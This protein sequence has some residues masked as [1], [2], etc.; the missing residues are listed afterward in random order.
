MARLFLP[1]FL[2]LDG[3][4]RQGL[5][6][7]GRSQPSFLHILPWS[8]L[9]SVVR[10]CCEGASPALFHPKR[11]P[12]SELTWPLGLGFLQDPTPLAAM[13]KA[14]SVIAISATDGSPGVSG[15]SRLLPGRVPQPDWPTNRVPLFHSQS[16]AHKLAT[17]VTQDAA[18]FVM[19]S[20]IPPRL[21]YRT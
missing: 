7:R 12:R 10:S 17:N 5:V 16:R 13:A 20:Q 1:T 14:S 15:G 2:S 18:A 6:L 19:R 4:M 21:L 9:P 3:L 11:V 8:M